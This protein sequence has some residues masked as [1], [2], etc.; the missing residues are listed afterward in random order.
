MKK[1]FPILILI[2]VSCKSK[3]IGSDIYKPEFELGIDVL[4][5]VSRIDSIANYYLVF[6]ENDKEFFKIVS[7]K[8]Q[9][10]YYNGVKV[11]TG[12][13]YTF[14]IQ[15]ITDRRTSGQNDRFTPINYL[16]I[17]QCQNFEKTEICTESSFELATASN[18]SGL[19]LRKK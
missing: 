9:A 2:L 14:K 17:T 8:N 16:D 10:K 15:Q 19:H 11:E 12:E 13:N 3:K 6:V 4:A 7:N 1:L 5:K 18:L